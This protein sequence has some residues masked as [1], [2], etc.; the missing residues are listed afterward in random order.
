MRVAPRT[1]SV[2]QNQALK[3]KADKAILAYVKAASVVVREVT[4]EFNAPLNSHMT[5]AYMEM[6]RMREGIYR[7]PPA[8]HVRLVRAEADALVRSF[9]LPRLYITCECFVESGQA[10]WLYL[11]IVWSRAQIMKNVKR[12]RDLALLLGDDTDMPDEDDP[13]LLRRA[14]DLFWEQMLSDEGESGDEVKPA[15][16]PFLRAR[17]AGRLVVSRNS[18][19][20]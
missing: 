17:A 19:V 20:Q 7:R 12:E 16:V 10:V 8:R 3:R 6:L 11:A 14:A 5:F 18:V 9:D 15:R 13:A 1:R 2:A 4:Q